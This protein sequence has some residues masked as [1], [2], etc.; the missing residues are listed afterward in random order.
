MPQQFGTE[1]LAAFQLLNSTGNASQIWRHLERAHIVCQSSAWRH[2]AIHSI[3]L[4]FA[5]MSRDWKEFLGQVPKT[6]LA[7]PQ[8][9]LGFTAAGNTGRSS[10]GAFEKMPVPPDLAH[11]VAR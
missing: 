4:C 7:V 11:F 10:V 6:I 1:M 9:L 8:S 2:F 3:M 5:F